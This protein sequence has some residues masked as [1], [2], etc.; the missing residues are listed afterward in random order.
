MKVD[1]TVLAIPAYIGAMGAEYAWQRR[2]P[3]PAGTRAGDY[4]TADTLASLSMGLGSLV[5]PYVAKRVLDP[6]TPGVGR[7]AKVLVGLGAAAGLA[8]TVG[9][10]LAKRLREGHLP[11]AGTVPAH[12]R[13][14]QDELAELRLAPGTDT[15]RRIRGSAASGTTKTSWTIRKAR[16]ALAVS[17]V[18]STALTV[19][20]T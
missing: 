20:T 15:P 5:A 10:V 9:D 7:W 1:L 14:V 19:A 6:V 13:E 3:V 8:T 12:V 11:D 16:G 18:T 4:Q 17:A 2:H